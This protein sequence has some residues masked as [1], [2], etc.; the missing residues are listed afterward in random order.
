MRI[1]RLIF[2]LLVF[3]HVTEGNIFKNVTSCIKLLKFISVIVYCSIIF[4]YL[5]IILYC[6]IIQPHI[7]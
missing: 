5:N 1:A 7:M 6:S 3:K 4:Y 2:V